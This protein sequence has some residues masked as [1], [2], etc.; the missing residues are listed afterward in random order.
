MNKRFKLIIQSIC[1]TCVFCLIAAAFVV[2]VRSFKSYSAP[3]ESAVV[4]DTNSNRCIKV[5]NNKVKFNLD[6]INFKS[7][8]VEYNFSFENNTKLNEKDINS[9]ALFY[10]GNESFT[11]TCLNWSNIKQGN[12]IY[13]VNDNKNID[14]ISIT[15]PEGLSCERI[16]LYNVDFNE[17]LSPI[18][19]EFNIYVIAFVIALLLST[20]VIFIE[21]KTLFLEKL[22][23]WVKRNLRLFAYLSVALIC[24]LVLGCI[25]ERITSSLVFSKVFNTSDFNIYLMLFISSFVFMCV[26][27]VYNNRKQILRPETAFVLI[28]LNVGFLIILICPIANANWDI[29]THFLNTIG[30]SSIFGQCSLSDMN[31]Y[32]ADLRTQPTVGLHR[33][34]SNIGY[35]EN[36][37]DSVV[38]FA[39]RNFSL[40]YFPGAVAAAI[41]QLFNASFYFKFNAIKLIN[42]LCY[43]C[44]CYFA[45]KKL[46]SGKIIL[47]VIALFPTNIFVATSCSYDWWVNAFSFLGMAYFIGEIQDSNKKITLRSTIIMCGA[48]FLAFIPKQIYIL[49]MLL[50]LFMPKNKFNTPKERR[51][52]ILIVLAF[53]LLMFVFLFIRSI[54]AISSVGDSRGGAGVNPLAQIVFILSNP[55]QYAKTLIMFIYEYLSVSSSNLYSCNFANLGVGI[56][57]AF[58]I[59]III[60]AVITDKDKCDVFTAKTH[61]RIIVSIFF[62]VS[63]VLVVTAL[64]VDFTPVGSKEILGVQGRYLTPMLFP[65]LS[66]IGSSKIINKIPKKQYYYAFYVICS[67]YLYINFAQTMLLRFLFS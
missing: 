27:F 44:L 30:M 63:V 12:Q 37:N 23:L 28:A 29:D 6:G 1:I 14:N 39:N 53:I 8:V 59:V 64:Y 40:E 58:Y 22:L 60:V 50:P 66:I 38:Y 31:V 52:Y 3:N 43:V 32:T 65:L 51:K 4:L 9:L 33:I 47:L 55:I 20:I 67:I 62:L 49:F 42:L 16:L 24:S 54:T 41:A 25:L 34:I 7:I 21:Y 48:L 18:Y 19:I 10:S 61:L 35:M 57:S 17:S 56:F 36:N 5:E 26:C 15:N 46:K 11:S 2:P 45:I 13:Y